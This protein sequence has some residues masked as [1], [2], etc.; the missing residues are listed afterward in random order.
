MGGLFLT[1]I[2]IICLAGVFICKGKETTSLEK[3]EGTEQYF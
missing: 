3:I 2:Q 1:A